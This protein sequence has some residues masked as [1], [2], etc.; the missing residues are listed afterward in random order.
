MISFVA[1]AQEA[2]QKPEV[3]ALIRE[4]AKYGLGAFMPHTH[5][6]EGFAPLPQDIVQLE[7]DLKVSFVPRNDDRLVG[8]APVG[9]VWDETGARVAA[10][11]FCT[12]AQHEPHWPK[13]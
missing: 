8:A 9:W 10:A 6:P 3:Q 7:G 11:C 4:L 13:K 12:G 1:Q 2:V 5:T